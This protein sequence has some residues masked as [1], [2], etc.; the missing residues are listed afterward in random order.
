LPFA[1]HRKGAGLRSRYKCAEICSSGVAFSIAEFITSKFLPVSDL[2]GYPH[3]D[4][5]C[6]VVNFIVSSFAT[7]I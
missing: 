1:K 7:R 4:V 3:R 6:G 5:F 2:D